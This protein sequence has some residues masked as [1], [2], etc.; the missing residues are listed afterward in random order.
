M[1]KKV[2]WDILMNPIMMCAIIG[3]FFKLLLG[4][5]A[6]VTDEAG[7][8][9]FFSPMDQAIAALMKPFGT[10]A[11]FLTGAS[12]QRPK[13]QFWPVWMVLMKVVV[14]AFCTYAFAVY[15][16]TNNPDDPS[17]EKRLQNFSFLYGMLPANS[18]P[19]IFAR[20]FDPEAAGLVATAILFGLVV[21]GPLMFGAAIFLQGVAHVGALLITI[22]LNTAGCSV[23]C[24]IF[25]IIMLLILREDWGYED[26][27]KLLIAAYLLVVFC[28]EVTTLLMNAQLAGPLCAEF[29]KHPIRT[30]TYSVVRSSA[31]QAS[32]NITLLITFMITTN[33]FVP[34]VK[35]RTV[36]HGLKLFVGVLVVSV[37]LGA[38]TAPTAEDICDGHSVI[39]QVAGSTGEGI[40]NMVVDSLYL[41]VFGGV[42]LIWAIKGSHD[43]ANVET[44]E[45]S[46]DSEAEDENEEDWEF[47]EDLTSGIKVKPWLSK[48][49]KSVMQGLAV[50]QVVDVM[51]SFVNVVL[52]HFES[53]LEGSYAMMMVIETLLKHAN[54]VIL[55]ALLTANLSFARH[56]MRKLILTFPSLFWSGEEEEDEDSF[57]G[58]A[59]VGTLASHAQF[60]AIPGHSNAQDMRRLSSAAPTAMGRVGNLYSVAAN[61][62]EIRGMPSTAGRAAGRAASVAGGAGVTQRG[63][64]QPAAAHSV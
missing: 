31:R 19:L 36:M 41:I 3:F 32:R 40:L 24:A 29:Q 37:V 9:K 46:S 17:A 26:P 51:S 20:Q 30:M 13:I 56:F 16:V 27:F 2:V 22:E 8:K 18:A 55:F 15:L 63:S 45:V 62:A 58:L 28:H 53:G 64:F 7:K 4:N 42:T 47:E 1:I 6:M 35:D 11:L 52:H 54:A 44:S 39:D 25:V 50:L 49:P 12:L 57:G 10:L 14:C 33:R 60:G 38:L 5:I 23:I 43:H 59:A 21:A 48:A 61:P 34:D